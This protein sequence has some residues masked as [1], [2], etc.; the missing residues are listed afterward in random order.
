M[1]KSNNDKIIKSSLSTLLRRFSNTTDIVGHIEKEYSE[2]VVGQ[3]KL[4][5]VDDNHILKKARINEQLLNKTIND[6]EKKGITTPILVISNGDRYEVVFSRLRYIACLKLNLVYVPVNVLNINELDMLI[7]LSSILRESKNRNIIELSLIFSCLQKKYKYTQKQ[8]AEMMNMSR[9]AVTN[10][11]RLH[12]LPSSVLTHL[13]NNEISVGHL[14]AISTLDNDEIKYYVDAILKDKLSVREIEKII[15]EKKNSINFKE[16]EKEVE[17][18]N[19]CSCQVSKKKIVLTFDNE[20][21][22]K[23]FIN[24]IK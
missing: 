12:K 3:V 18:A 16:I 10:I 1:N 8:I 15:F 20:E 7:F 9:S 21:D 6:I 22:I 14:R 5:L 11:I 13:A 23:T 17:K 24:K 4:S 2:S 19:K